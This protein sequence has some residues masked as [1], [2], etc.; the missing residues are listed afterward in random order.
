MI[1]KSLKKWYTV[2][3]YQDFL[4]GCYTIWNIDLLTKTF[5]SMSTTLVFAATKS[6]GSGADAAWGGHNSSTA[7][8]GL[9][10]TTDQEAS[11]MNV[12]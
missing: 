4:I 8:E 7:E 3:I 6:G 10:I 5:F 9:Q 1:N 2:H 11:A 12:Q